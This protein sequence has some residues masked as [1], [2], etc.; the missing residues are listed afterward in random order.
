MGTGKTRNEEKEM[1]NDGNGKREMKN[2]CMPSLHSATPGVDFCH[3]QEIAERKHMLVWRTMQTIPLDYM[4]KYF[5]SLN[6][7]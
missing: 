4:Y 1:G 6:T 5:L 2:G 7:I 3:S